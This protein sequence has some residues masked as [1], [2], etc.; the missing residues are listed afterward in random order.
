MHLRKTSSTFSPVRALVSRKDSSG[1]G[2]GEGEGRGREGRGEQR[3]D[4]S[5]ILKQM[6]GEQMLV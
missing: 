4:V 6:L 2:E 1:G 5:F 3:T